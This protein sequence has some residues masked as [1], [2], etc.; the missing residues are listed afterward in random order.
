MLYKKQC[1]NEYW[2][3]LVQQAFNDTCNSLVRFDDCVLFYNIW[4]ASLL[5]QS[6]I[7]DLLIAKCGDKWQTINKIVVKYGNRGNQI[8]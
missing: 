4:S 2:I 8:Q 7:I 1:W 6:F 5:T 3:V